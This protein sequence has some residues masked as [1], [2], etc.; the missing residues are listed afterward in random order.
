MPI[1]GRSDLEERILP[2]EIGNFQRQVVAASIFAYSTQF[3]F[4]LADPKP[5]PVIRL[6]SDANFE[7]YYAMSNWQQKFYFNIQ[8]ASSGT[9]MFRY[10]EPIDLNG[11]DAQYPY[12]LPVTTVF[13]KSGSI[14]LPALNDPASIPVHTSDFVLIGARLFP[15]HQQQ[16]DAQVITDLRQKSDI[17][18]SRL[19]Y[20]PT[21]QGPGSLYT[22]AIVRSSGYSYSASFNFTANNEPL[23]VP[24]TT[25]SDAHFEVFYFL[26][27]TTQPFTVN[28]KYGS[29]NVYLFEQEIPI[30]LIA[31]NA[32]RPFILPVTTVF[33]KKSSIVFEVTN[34]PASGAHTAHFVMK[35]ARLFAEEYLQ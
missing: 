20:L 1:L 24:I 28:I 23:Q 7:A 18:T 35:G 2:D 9:E 34:G 5:V 15:V 21:G 25:F 3:V 26:C 10:P 16:V 19:R 11:G 32:L 33:E 14:V 30:N 29:N 12:I 22:P 8:D 13:R 17:T 6:F 31:G 4:T 27:D